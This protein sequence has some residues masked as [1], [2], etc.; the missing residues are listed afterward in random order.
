MESASVSGPAKNLI[1]FA[2]RAA[3]AGPGSR[4]A[5]VSVATFERGGTATPS[6]FVTAASA[7]GIRVHL[8]AE[9]RRYDP[10]TLRQLRALVAEVDPDIIQT[11]NIKSHLL[12]RL[13]G[14]GRRYPWIAFHH[15]YTAVDMRDRL[16]RV[17][18]RWS[19]PGA[20]RVLVVC[21]AFAEQV[22]RIGVPAARIVVQ[23]NSVDSFVEV[24]PERIGHER[25]RLN[26]PDGVPIALTVGRLSLEKGHRDLI[27]AAGVLRS[28]A[29]SL[30][31]RLVIVGEGPERA[32][33]GRACE[34]LGL[35]DVVVFA[36]YQTDV[37]PYYAA[38]RLLVL[39]SW[40]EGS[41]NVVLEGMA[42]GVPV[43]A[44]HVGGVPEIV[45]DGVTGL[46]VPPRNPAAL[47]NGMLRLLQD[48]EFAGRLRTAARKRVAEHYSRDAYRASLLKIYEE[49]IGSHSRDGIRER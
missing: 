26:I 4:I 37:R 33:L 28:I 40:S 23:H 34:R 5:T 13:A 29:P 17:F 49:A 12:V 24:A 41:P 38:A 39:P 16:Y 15:G 47:A 35:R 44:T 18:D 1:E 19:L 14:L 43:V 10:G 2:R 6:P 27:D 3:Q 25:A 21:E 22:R 7:A 32:A 11:H 31:Y 36:G 42:A 46:V 30:S 9:R 48:A 20:H 8:L 45:R